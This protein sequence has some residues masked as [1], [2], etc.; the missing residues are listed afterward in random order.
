MAST[1]TPKTVLLKGSPVSIEGIAGGAIKPGH[2]V[3]QLSTA[4]FVVQATAGIRD[5][6]II[7]R[8]NEIHGKDI[9]TAYADAGRFYGWHLKPG[10]EI[11]A[12]V[13]ANAAAIVIGDKLVHDGT[14]CLK[15]MAALVTDNSGGSANTTLQDIGATPLEAEIANNFADVAAII[16]ANVMAAGLVAYATEALDNSAVAAVARIKVRIA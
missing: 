1:D 6:P 14:G 11:Y 4:K 12:F 5:A 16:N 8:E 2:F 7:A 10:D 9:D 13:P 3:K 15:K